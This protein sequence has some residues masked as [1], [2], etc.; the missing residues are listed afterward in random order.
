[1]KRFWIGLTV[2]IVIGIILVPVVAACYLRFGYAPVA[3]AEPPFPFEKWLATGALK[4]RIAREAPATSPI[5]ATEENLVA[6]AKIYKEDCAVCHGIHD[7]SKTVIA[8]GMYPIPPQF[9]HGDD[10]ADDPVGVTYWK[11]ANGIRLT[12]MPSFKDSLTA[13]Q[14]WQVS[15]LL[16]NTD[17]LPPEAGKFVG[18]P[19]PK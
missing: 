12:G 10:L 8:K 9:F 7:R 13:T 4:A 15:Q 1:M 5:Q 19:S 3:T 11:I 18:I 6:G 16:A 14:M 2:G 17:T